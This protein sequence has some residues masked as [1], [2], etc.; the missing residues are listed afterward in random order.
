MKVYSIVHHH[1]AVRNAPL[2]PDPKNKWKWL[3]RSL[4]SIDEKLILVEFAQLHLFN[5]CVYYS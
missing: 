1:I 4:F 2:N 5:V 3:I